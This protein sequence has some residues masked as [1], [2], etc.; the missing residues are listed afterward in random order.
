MYVSEGASILPV[1]TIFLLTFRTVPIVQYFIFSLFLLFLF[2]NE[3]RSI[4]RKLINT[5]LLN[6]LITLSMYQYISLQTGVAE[7]MTHH[8]T[9]NIKVHYNI[10]GVYKY[11]HIAG[12]FDLHTMQLFLL[13]VKCC[14]FRLKSFTQYLN[15]KLKH[16]EKMPQCALI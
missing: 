14:L 6:R 9:T 5:H 12:Q 10:S 15:N 13:V 1:S 3:N 4:C 11:M 2:Y 8:I 7:H 16:K